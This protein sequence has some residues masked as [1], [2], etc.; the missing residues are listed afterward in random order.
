MA[1]QEKRPS[2]AGSLAIEIDHFSTGGRTAELNMTSD[3]PST[4]DERRKVRTE[5][6]KIQSSSNQNNVQ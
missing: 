1:Q 5:W 2:Q 3:I 4:S 6:M